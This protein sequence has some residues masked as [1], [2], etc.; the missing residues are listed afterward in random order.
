MK[1]DTIAIHTDFI[2]LESLLKLA[3]ACETGG[4]AKLAINDG[5]VEVNGEV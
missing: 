4:E 5:L 1:T 3:G 2:K